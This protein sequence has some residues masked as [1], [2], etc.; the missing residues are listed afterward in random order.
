MCIRDRR[1]GA[2]G[3]VGIRERVALL[4]GRFEVESAPGEGTTLVIELP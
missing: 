4:G 3:L 1:Q 2:L